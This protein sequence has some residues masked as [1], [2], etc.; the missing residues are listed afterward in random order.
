MTRRRILV[1]L[2]GVVLLGAL[3]LLV[4]ILPPAPLA[5][6]PRGLVLANV[7]VINPGLG[8]AEGRTLRV[9]GERIESIGAAAADD[10]ADAR[11]SGAYLIPGLIDMHVHFPPDT[12]LRQ[13]ELFAFLFL[14][15]GVTTV[16]D[17]GDVD[18]TAT[19][20]A[21]EGVRSGVFPGPASSPAGRWSTDP[22]RSR[23]TRW[24]W[25][26]RAGRRRRWQEL[27]TAVSTA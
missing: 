22:R 24:W 11:Y 9:A 5:L 12:G 2:V 21:R 18:G 1:A 25:A 16:R 17:A 3:G 19:A 4:A 7:T 10:E 13:T 14:A 6:P 20:P 27:P 23:R 26:S 8:R 15:H